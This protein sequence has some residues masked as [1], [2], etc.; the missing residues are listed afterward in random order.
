MTGHVGMLVPCLMVAVIAVGLSKS[1]GL[2][3]FDLNMVAKGLETLQ[4]LLLDSTQVMVWVLSIRPYLL[5]ARSFPALVAHWWRP[6]SI[7]P[8]LG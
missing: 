5:W 3:I 1:M 7:R 6:L 4:L 2:S 8:Y